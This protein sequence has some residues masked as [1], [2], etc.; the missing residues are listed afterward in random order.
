MV[1]KIGNIGW[2]IHIWR[3]EKRDAPCI[4]IDLWFITGHFVRKNL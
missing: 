2:K 4:K 3:I 1:I